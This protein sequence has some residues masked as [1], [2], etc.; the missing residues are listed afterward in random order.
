MPF[1][2]I[3]AEPAQQG[4]VAALVRVARVGYVETE[5]EIRRAEIVAQRDAGIRK[6]LG[7]GL[8]FIAWEM[9]V[10]KVG[11]FKDGLGYVLLADRRPPDAAF[12]LANIPIGDDDRLQLAFPRG[13]PFYEIAK[14]LGLFDRVVV[15]GAFLPA[16]DGI[17][18][19]DRLVKRPEADRHSEPTLFPVRFTALAKL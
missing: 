11:V 9:V 14:S 5:N 10:V 4:K 8:K 13:T 15:S 18:D 12:A 6:A 7:D 3:A 19:S 17:V 2:S 1:S 16:G